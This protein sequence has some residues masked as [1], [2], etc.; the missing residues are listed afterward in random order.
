M[1]KKKKQFNIYQS[2]KNFDDENADPNIIQAEIPTFGN[3][4]LQRIDITSFRN[5]DDKH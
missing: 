5:I 4:I 3:E 2:A 1:P